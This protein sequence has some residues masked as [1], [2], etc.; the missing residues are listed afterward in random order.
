MIENIK[1]LRLFP[2]F[3][4]VK[5]LSLRRISD[6]IKNKIN[7]YKIQIVSDNHRR[8]CFCKCKQPDTK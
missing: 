2:K 4:I 5:Q 6:K 3:I 1:N 7:E 8:F